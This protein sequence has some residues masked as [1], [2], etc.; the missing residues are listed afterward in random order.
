MRKMEGD[1]EICSEETG[2]IRS[3]MWGAVRRIGATIGE[4]AGALVQNFL[5][6][7]RMA[8]RIVAESGVGTTSWSNSGQEEGCSPGRSRG[9]PVNNLLPAGYPLS[10]GRTERAM[11]SR[12][13]MSS[14][15]SHCSITRCTPAS[16]R[17][18]S[19]STISP[20]VPAR[21]AAGR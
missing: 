16:E 2:D 14:T 12:A 4:E 5:E 3:P 9:A 8:C 18:P 19:R 21:T 20:G 6:E 7:R 10:C 17:C 1:P 13:S 15:S 11:A